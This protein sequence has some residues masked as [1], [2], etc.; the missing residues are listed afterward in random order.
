MSGVR[1]G[2]ETKQ[3]YRT[4]DFNSL[5][6]PKIHIASASCMKRGENLFALLRMMDRYLKARPMT[7]HLH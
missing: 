6:Y 7:T 2:M 4:V 3:K 5:W 1:A